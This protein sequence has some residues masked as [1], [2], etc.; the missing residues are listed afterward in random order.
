MLFGNVV[1]YTKAKNRNPD[2]LLASEKACK[3]RMKKAAI[4]LFIVYVSVCWMA[5]GDQSAAQDNADGSTTP[6]IRTDDGSLGINI[7]IGP[8]KVEYTAIIDTGASRTGI[9]ETTATT[10]GLRPT[11]EQFTAQTF[12]GDFQFPISART[13]WTPQGLNHDLEVS[14][15]IFLDAFFE[16]EAGRVLR[17]AFEP[18][19][20]ILGSDTLNATSWILDLSE[21]TLQLTSDSDVSFDKPI[22]AIETRLWDTKFDCLVDTGLP[23]YPH[24]LV[25]PAH[26]IHAFLT[27][28][29]K[30]FQLRPSPFFEGQQVRVYYDPE[31]TIEGLNG[32]GITVA[33]LDNPDTDRGGTLTEC[34]IGLE[35]LQSNR[36]SYDARSSQ[37]SLQGK[38]PLARYNRSGLTDMI[39]APS[40]N[41]I[42]FEIEKLESD[43][44]AFQAGLRK[45]DLILTF[46]TRPLPEY[47]RQSLMSVLSASAGTNIKIQ[48]SRPN[49]AEILDTVIIL[50]DTLLD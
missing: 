14:P 13:H 45:G 22:P 49:E 18:S 28:S 47:T 38:L 16:T 8:N 31:G 12:Y 33:I 44:P 25:S 23:N 5:W 1:L 11:K 4:F 20:I 35:Y 41:G 9:T 3:I 17:G 24:I 29:G 6:L 34:I 32:T 36:L 15:A 37:A 7:S 43:S 46:N 40:A 27:A 21:M 10:L 2:F 48:Y 42:A 50:Q 26:P 19:G 39:T 30:P